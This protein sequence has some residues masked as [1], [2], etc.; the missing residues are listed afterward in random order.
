MPERRR[1][2]G[3]SLLELLAVLALVA[4]LAGIAYPL[5]R[6]Y[7]EDSAHARAV[8]DLAGCTLALEAHFSQG[9]TYLGADAAGVCALAS[10][11]QGQA[12]YSISYEQLTA[13]TYVLRATP[14][15]GDCTEAGTICIEVNQNGD[16]RLF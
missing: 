16:R 9:F 8:A 6:G 3:F 13:T 1:Q 11:P 7:V 10:P 12:R 4:V 15:G 5:Y 2:G 14:V